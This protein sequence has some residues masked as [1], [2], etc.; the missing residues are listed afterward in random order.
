MRRGFSHTIPRRWIF[1]WNNSAIHTYSRATG[2]P[3]MR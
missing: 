1:L 3:R 2:V